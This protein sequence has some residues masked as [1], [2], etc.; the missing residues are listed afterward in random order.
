MVE[1]FKAAYWQLIRL[2]DL[3]I[4]ER[5]IGIVLHCW[6]RSTP[7][8]KLHLF[9]HFQLHFTEAFGTFQ[10]C[11]F[12]LIR[13]PLKVNE[14]TYDNGYFLVSS[15]V[16]LRCFI[17]EDLSGLSTEPAFGGMDSRLSD[18]SECNFD[19]ER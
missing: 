19:L 13:L 10:T 2:V 3:S 18:Y 14:G 12:L 4:S 17:I 15:C 9:M 8:S 7:S 16:C 11:Y 1:N 6:N 5:Y